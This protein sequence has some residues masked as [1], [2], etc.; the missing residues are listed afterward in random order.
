MVGDCCDVRQDL[1]RHS[2]VDCAA[3]WCGSIFNAESTNV[4]AVENHEVDSEFLPGVDK[5][6]WSFTFV[7]EHEF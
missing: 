5:N 3:R 7:V 6:G 2:G 1:D 4:D